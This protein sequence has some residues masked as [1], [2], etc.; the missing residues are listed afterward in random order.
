MQRSLAQRRF[1]FAARAALAG[2]VA[3]GCSSTTNV[4]EMISGDAGVPKDA[5]VEAASLDGAADS[6]DAL[7]SDASSAE[8][9]PA[10]DAAAE[11]GSASDAGHE[12][13]AGDDSAVIDAAVL[14]ASDASLPIDAADAAPTYTILH[15]IVGG[16]NAGD[17]EA[18]SP[19]VSG[20]YIAQVMTANCVQPISCSSTKVTNGDVST[21]AFGDPCGVVYN[22]PTNGSLTLDGTL[23]F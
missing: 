22:S 7:A 17:Y 10:M 5:D 20:P 16:P 15:C 14:D 8:A 4:Y 9:S 18:C 2:V 11:T 6:G 3:A 1:R 13:S 21:C 12:G 23:G 19:N